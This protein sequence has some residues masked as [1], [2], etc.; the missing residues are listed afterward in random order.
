[1][2]TSTKPLGAFGAL[3]RAFGAVARSPGA[4][5]AAVLLY[6]LLSSITVMQL[7]SGLTTL[8]GASQDQL[9]RVALTLAGV[10]LA[11]EIFVGPLFAALA[12][13]VGSVGP[14]DEGRGLYDALNF[15]LNR[16]GRMFVPHAIA[17]I[18]IQLG[19]I[20]LLP[21]IL[22]FLQYAFVD[23]VASLEKEKW[24]LS[25]SK[26]LTRGRRRA[27][28][29]LL[30]PYLV[31]S[32]VWIFVDLWALEQGGWV[33]LASEMLRISYSFLLAVAAVALYHDRVKPRPTPAEG[34]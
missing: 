6:A 2:A 20:V 22:F 24:P 32:Q 23:P 30:L 9:I 14:E 16:Y 31:A 15:A 21:G 18:S 13:F 26:K 5:L 7:E 33:P 3:G 4:S 28:F 34:E 1:M 12:V 27:L 10:G 8:D 11:I 17:Q 19:M 29:L 25:R